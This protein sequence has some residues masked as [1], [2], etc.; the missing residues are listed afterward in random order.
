MARI[1]GALGQTPKRAKTLAE[2]AAAKY[3]VVGSEK[4]EELTEVEAW[5]AAHR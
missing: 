5:L 1:L 4:T 3:R 2:L